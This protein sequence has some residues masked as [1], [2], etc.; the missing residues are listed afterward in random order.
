[1]DL[2]RI[3]LIIGLILLVLLSIGIYFALRPIFFTPDTSGG[4]LPFVPQSTTNISLGGGTGSIE[5]ALEDVEKYVRAGISVHVKDARTVVVEWKNLPAGTTKLS[6][7]REKIGTKTWSFWQTVA[8]GSGSGSAEVTLKA[9]EDATNY[10]YYGQAYSSSGETLWASAPTET[11]VAVVD[12][13]TGSGQASSGPPA[14]GPPAAPTPPAPPTPPGT[15]PPIG[16]IGPINPTPLP[17]PPPPAAPTPPPPPPSGIP[18]YAPNGTI[19]GYIPFQTAS[20]WVGHADTSHIELGWQNLPPPTDMIVVFR[21]PTGNEPWVEL[22]RQQHPDT[23]GP[24]TIRLI[25]S[26]ISEPYYYKMEAFSGNNR[27]AIYGP[28]LLEATH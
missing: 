15:P 26:S 25:D 24:S 10:T 27:I 1:M 12:P 8:A 6:L 20:F 5:G 11:Q 9:G 19:T 16:P 22:L 3:Y 13:S 7:Y 2:V 23:V 4:T 18:Y 28:E 14:G 17:P 21:S